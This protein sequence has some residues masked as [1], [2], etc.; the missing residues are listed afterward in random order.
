MSRSERRRAAPV[1]AVLLGLVVLGMAMSTVVSTPVHNPG[2]GGPLV[3]SLT[4]R[5]RRYRRP[6][7]CPARG[8]AAAQSHRLAAVRHLVRGGQSHQRV[9]HPGLP[10][11]P[12][13]AAAGLGV[14]ASPGVLAA[15]PGLRRDPALGVSRREAASRPVASTVGDPA[16]LRPGARRGGIADRRGGRG[17]A[18]RSHHG[19]RG[20]DP[21][22]CAAGSCR[23]TSRPSCCRWPPGWPGSSSRF[24]PTATQTASAASSSSGCTAGPPSP[25]SRSSSACSW[26]RWPWATHRGRATIP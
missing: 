21:P 16:R 5:P 26:S 4:W 3:D 23:S 20:P 17:Q 9:R 14:G 22:A 1:A 25:W 2:T 18:R 6:R 8:P 10:D 19:Q 24:R 12:R 11:A 13:D 7:W 15:V